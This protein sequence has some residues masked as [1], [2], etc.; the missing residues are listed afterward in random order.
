MTTISHTLSEL[1]GLTGPHATEA[2]DL[3]VRAQALTRQ[4]ALA[5][6]SAWDPEAGANEIREYLENCR[7]VWGALERTG[8][9][10]PLG[11]FEAMFADVEWAENTKALHP[12]AD[13]VVATLVKDEIPMEVYSFMTHPWN[14]TRNVA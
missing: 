9:K 2:M 6:A 3:V 13:A 4:E 8:R 11:W 14:E 12:I 5:L 10:L 7:E 1:P